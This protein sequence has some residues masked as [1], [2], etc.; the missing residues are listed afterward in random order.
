M[1]IIIYRSLPTFIEV[2][3]AFDVSYMVLWKICT[4]VPQPIMLHMTI[5]NCKKY[6]FF[7]VTNGVRQGG[8]LFPIRFNV[9][10]DELLHRLQQNDIG[11]H[12]G[13]IFIGVS[14]Y[15]DDLLLLCPENDNYMQRICYRI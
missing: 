12:I 15:V 6:F 11:C 10:F 14:C 4:V 5:W 8:V 2:L 7:D 3:L 9:Y 13:T 1:Y